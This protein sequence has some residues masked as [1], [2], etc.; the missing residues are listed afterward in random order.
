[1]LIA[2]DGTGG[3]PWKMSPLDGSLPPEERSYDTSMKDSF[4]HHLVRNYIG[5][6]DSLYFRGPTMLGSECSLIL[7]ACMAKAAIALKQNDTVHLAGYSRGGAIA[8]ALAQEIRRTFSSAMIPVLALFDAVDREMAFKNVR[9]IPGNVA[10]AFHARRDPLTNSRTSFGNCGL[11]AE[12]PCRLETLTFMTTHGGMGGVPLTGRRVFDSI[13]T[14]T[15]NFPSITLGA[16]TYGGVSRWVGPAMEKQ[17]SQLVHRW[18][19]AKLR[20]RGI[21][22]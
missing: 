12:S 10:F 5:K 21:V 6:G 4:I 19:W 17:Q 1:M 15:E 22:S 2:I 16:T 14:I 8:I 18:M 13:Q 7:G 11:N 3:G 20:K 9:I